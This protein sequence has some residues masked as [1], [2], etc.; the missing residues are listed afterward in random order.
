VPLA[1]ADGLQLYYEW[2]GPEAPPVLLLLHGALQSGRTAVPLLVIHG[3]QDEMV[4]VEEAR[5][6][7]VSVPQA[8]K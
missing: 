6:L 7:A 8:V 5:R 1:S 4:P 2:E 3:E